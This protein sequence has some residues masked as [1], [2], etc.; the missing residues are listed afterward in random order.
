[1]VDDDV[2]RTDVVP[3][4]VG[5][6]AP[7]GLECGPSYDVGPVLATTTFKFSAARIQ[8]DP[9]GFPV[10]PGYPRESEP[11]DFRPLQI[12]SLDNLSLRGSPSRPMSGMDGFSETDNE[13]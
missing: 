4:G 8:T 1:M 3:P 5:K 6:S 11:W 9:L 2:R 7:P 10:R 13:T 12:P